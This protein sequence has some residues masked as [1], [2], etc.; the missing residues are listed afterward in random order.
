MTAS[1]P[2]IAPAT[3]R[4]AAT[5]KAAL[6]GRLS[7]AVRG[8]SDAAQVNAALSDIVPGNDTSDGAFIRPQW[9][10]ELWTPV[11]AEQFFVNSV[12]SAPLTGM[13]VLG[14]K[15][16][17]RPVV[18]PYAGNKTEI[19]SGPV[20]IGP[21]S[22]DAYRLAGGWDIDRVFWDLGDGSIA[23]AVLDMA[24]QDLAVKEETKVTDALVAAATTTPGEAA[25]DVFSAISAV[26][27]AVVGAGA[28]VSF[29]GLSPDLFGQLFAPTQATAPWWLTG[30][31]ISLPGGTADLPIGVRV[32]LANGLPDGTALGG[33]RR[34]FTHYSTPSIRVQALNIPNGGID[35]A[36]FHYAADLVH[37]AAGL[38]KA[39]IPPVIP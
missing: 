2:T 6:V 20:A 12:G 15:W 14:W 25:T 37:N 31:T 38:A 3:R 18:G 10:D 34:A 27:N 1:L 11:L 35:V 24:A 8:A 28:Q 5:D 22:A 23:N 9:I 7:A 32:G 19:P 29:I 30:A 4:P 39:T 21:A 36:L 13:K 16:T 26:V 17:T 33:D